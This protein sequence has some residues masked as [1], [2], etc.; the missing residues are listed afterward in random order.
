LDPDKLPWDGPLFQYELDPGQCWSQ[1]LF[2][3]Q[4]VEQP[5]VGRHEMSCL[6]SLPFTRCYQ[7]AAGDDNGETGVAGN[8]GLVECR[9]AFS[10][11]IDPV[12][13]DRLLAVLQRYE[14]QLQGRGSQGAEDALCLIRDPAAVPYLVR[15]LNRSR[16][17]VKV[18]AALAR[19][20]PASMQAR[21]VLTD[22]LT[23]ENPFHVIDTLNVLTREKCA[24]D[25]HHLLSLLRYSEKCWIGRAV[26]QYI[27]SMDRPEYR[28][29]F[30]DMNL[31]Q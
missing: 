30:K 29:L 31:K 1:T 18:L 12:S 23:A 7:L 15:Q 2:L 20:A 16:S 10:L 24:V 11:V 17:S 25:P 21:S 27:D 22:Q 13:P 19:L 4:V 26:R 3:Q 14:T 8:D 5:K 9:C 6:C 28:A